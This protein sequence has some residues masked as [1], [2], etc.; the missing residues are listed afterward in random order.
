MVFCSF[1]LR[2]TP[3]SNN[4]YPLPPLAQDEITKIH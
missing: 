1:F 3:P 4:V 2:N